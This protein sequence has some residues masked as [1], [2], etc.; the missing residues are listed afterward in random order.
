[1]NGLQPAAVDLEKEPLV[2]SRRWST[3]SPDR[4][5]EDSD[6]DASRP[7]LPSLVPLS[8][9]HPL[10][11]A[12]DESWN[13]EEFLLSR[14]HLP[15]EELRAELREYLGNLKEELGELINDDYEEFI[16]LGLGLRGEGNRLEELRHPLDALKIEVEVSNSISRVI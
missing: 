5:S 11:S 16:S 9:D 13:V 12:D 15:L 3:S 14:V 2:S 4:R 8:H 10:L 7:D 1:M 6:Q